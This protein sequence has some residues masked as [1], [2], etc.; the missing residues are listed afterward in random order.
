MSNEVQF[1]FEKE[2]RPEYNR[3]GSKLSKLVVRLSGGLIED[4]EQAHYVV[5]TFVVLAIITSSLMFFNSKKM[6]YNPSQ[7]ELLRTMT[8][9]PVTR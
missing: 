4:E 3:S 2:Q 1:D 9:P 6:P 5:L 8:L 7:Q